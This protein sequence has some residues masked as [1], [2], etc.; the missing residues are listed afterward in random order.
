[1]FWGRTM[2][3]DEDT[4]KNLLTYSMYLHRRTREMVNATADNAIG[5]YTPE[6]LFVPELNPTLLEITQMIDAFE[7]GNRESFEMLDKYI[8]AKVDE[9]RH[10]RIM[11]TH[12]ALRLVT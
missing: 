2:K 9:A 11:A 10:A 4:L 7:E 3:L 1:M 6:G 8:E 5:L 12:P